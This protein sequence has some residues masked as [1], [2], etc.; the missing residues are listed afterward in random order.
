MGC[1]DEG[2]TTSGGGAATFAGC[3]TMSSITGSA[4]QMLVSD[5]STTSTFGSCYDRG[6]GDRCGSGRDGGGGCVPG[7]GCG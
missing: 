4:L 5:G 7:N 3:W 6:Y 2:P 1:I